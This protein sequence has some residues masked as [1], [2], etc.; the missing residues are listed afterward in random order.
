MMP[1]YL[2]FWPCITA[3]LWQRTI[4]CTILQERGNVPSSSPVS[5]D[6]SLAISRSTFS[7]T[8]WSSSV[9]SD[10]LSIVRKDSLLNIVSLHC[11]SD[12]VYDFTVHTSARP[13]CIRYNVFYQSVCPSVV[14]RSEVVYGARARN[15][16]LWRGTGGK[17]SRS[18]KAK[19]TFAGL[20]EETFSTPFIAFQVYLLRLLLSHKFGVRPETRFFCLD[21]LSLIPIFSLNS[22]S[23]VRIKLWTEQSLSPNHQS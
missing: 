20:A 3:T 22:H 16:Q 12:P 13:D 17:S 15:N 5:L 18:H 8:A 14:R 11:K 6:L 2:S 23:T 9:L 10:V 4:R 19:V 21:S 1:E 7:L